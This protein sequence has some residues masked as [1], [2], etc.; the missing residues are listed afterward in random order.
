MDILALA[1]GQGMQERSSM[2]RSLAATRATHASL[3]N[4]HSQAISYYSFLVYLKTKT[5]A[6]KRTSK[7]S[8]PERALEAIS[9]TNMTI[10][11]PQQNVFLKFM[12]FV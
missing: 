2:I 5:T 8:R 1:P 11:T 7:K 6:I 3:A 4:G 9:M 12:I 10:M